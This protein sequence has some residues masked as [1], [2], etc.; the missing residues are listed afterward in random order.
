MAL[1]PASLALKDLSSGLPDTSRQR[2][3]LVRYGDREDVRRNIG[4]NFGMEGSCGSE[5]EHWTKRRSQLLAYR[6]TE[7]DQRVLR[8]ID[9]ELTVLAARIDRARTEEE[10]EW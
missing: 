2:A 7:D 3:V 5:A 1:V 9:D 6:A 4:S 8:W 10:R